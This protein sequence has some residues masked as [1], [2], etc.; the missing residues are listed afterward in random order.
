MTANNF[1][2]LKSNL[3]TTLL[4]FEFS[5]EL[6][7]SL[8]TDDFINGL[9]ELRQLQPENNEFINFIENFSDQQNLNSIRQ[10]DT[11]LRDELAKDGYVRD[12]LTYIRNSW[13]N[14][15]FPDEVMTRS[16]AAGLQRVAAVVGTGLTAIANSVASKA[17][18]LYQD[19]IGWWDMAK[20]AH[21]KQNEYYDIMER[22]IRE[23]EAALRGGVQSNMST[24]ANTRSP[25]IVDLDGD[26]VETTTT[27]DGTHFDHDNNG[28]AEKTSWVGKDDGLLV[29]DING[30]GQIDDGTELFGNNSVLSNGQKASNGFEALADLDSNNDGVFNNSDAS[31]AQVK[32]WKDANQ[33]GKTDEGELL[34]LEQAGIESIDLDYQNSN[35]VD[36][37]GNT[38]GQIGSFDKEN[39][40]QG[41]ISDIW[42]NTD[43]MD[44]VDK[45]N[46]DIPADIAALPNVI[47]FGN[48][49]DLHT[50]MAAIR[51]MEETV[52][53]NFTETPAMII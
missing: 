23:E 45:T 30:N 34:T 50:A 47:G 18:Y 21:D 35:T 20:W 53:M 33:N 11:L 26:G 5:Q 17:F 44:T 14:I 16:I 28:F 1:N 52:I 13:A 19:V 4:D 7:N 36:I 37:N 8:L 12:V 22:K 15:I 49:H 38:V 24:A 29:R 9:L 32:V 27:E 46:I 31:W 48:V 39:G 41:N 2:T 25:L 42:F 51:Y 43:L 10:F 40:T 3:T 6:I